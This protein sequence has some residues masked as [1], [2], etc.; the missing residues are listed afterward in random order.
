MGLSGIGTGA[1]AQLRVDGNM[2]GAGLGPSAE[3]MILLQEEA[4]APTSPGE[5]LSA[6]EGTFPRKGVRG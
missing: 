4:C 5:T 6:S 2:E 1:L 3:A